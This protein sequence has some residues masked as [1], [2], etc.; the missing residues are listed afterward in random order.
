MCVCVCIMQLK[1][2][3]HLKFH[4]PRENLRLN[5]FFYIFIYHIN[6]N[7]TALSHGKTYAL[8]NIDRELF[9]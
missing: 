6:M 3:L 8:I 2:I 1:C 7:K 5:H 4:L 9:Q